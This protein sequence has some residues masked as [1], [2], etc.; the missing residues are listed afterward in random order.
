QAREFL[1]RKGLY[2]GP[3]LVRV[4]IGRLSE[5]WS[6]DEAHQAHERRN[7]TPKAPKFV[8]H[9]RTRFSMAKSYAIS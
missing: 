4:P 5:N 9:H 7:G 3:L 8:S 6:S 2:P 1:R